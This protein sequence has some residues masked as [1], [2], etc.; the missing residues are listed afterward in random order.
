MKFEEQVQVFG[1]TKYDTFTGRDG[2]EIEGG[3]VVWYGTAYPT[4]LENKKGFEVR[5]Q[6]F[7]KDLI[8]KEFDMFKDKRFPCL[9]VMTGHRDTNLADP[10]IDSIIVR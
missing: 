7:R 4:D 9:A 2:N 5:K 1:V 8:N 3:C 10:V 6:T